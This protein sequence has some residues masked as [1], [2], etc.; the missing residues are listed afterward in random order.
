MLYSLLICVCS[1]PFS[2][3]RPLLSSIPPDNVDL[4][5]SRL[6]TN[7]RL[8]GTFS[9]VGYNYETAGKVVQVGETLPPTFL[10]RLPLGERGRLALY[11]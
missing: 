6:G 3:A 10:K 1:V 4:V 8:F 11:L 7:I 9:Q 2:S 5:V